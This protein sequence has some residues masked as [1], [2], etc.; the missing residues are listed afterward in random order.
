MDITRVITFM[1]GDALNDRSLSFIPAVS[2][3]GGDA[4]DHSVSHHS[5]QAGTVAKYRAM[6]LWKM[7]QIAGFLSKLKTA[8]DAEGKSLLDTSLV[9]ISSEIADGNRHNHDDKPILLAGQCVTRRFMTFAIGRLLDGA[10]DDAWVEQLTIRAQAA[11]GSL[12]S[13]IRTVLL[14]AAFRSRESMP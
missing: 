12:K 3:A 9:F 5:N 6:V 8:Q 4:G 11:D 14:S 10:D 7:E 13:I 1:M 2:S